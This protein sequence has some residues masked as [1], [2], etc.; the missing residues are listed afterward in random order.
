MTSNKFHHRAR[1]GTALAALAISL[2]TVAVAAPTTAI[3]A[4]F[5]PKLS[6][7]VP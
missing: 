3:A 7:V 5:D 4:Q 2:G 6:A 1:M